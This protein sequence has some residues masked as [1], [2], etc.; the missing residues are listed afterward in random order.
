MQARHQKIKFYI[1]S[2]FL[3]Y[4]E[5]ESSISR[6]FNIEIKIIWEVRYQYHNNEVSVS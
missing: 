6:I 2:Q 3:Q 5:N 1:V 4:N